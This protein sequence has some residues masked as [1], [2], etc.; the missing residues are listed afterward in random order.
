M[1]RVILR[2]TTLIAILLAPVGPTY[3]A[4]IEPFPT[5]EVAP[6]LFV[7]AA[8]IA[9]A[10][11][12]NLGAIANLGFVIGREA[13]A[14]IDTGGSLA[15]GQRLA[16]SIRARTDLPVRW[17][18]NT[19]VH[20]DHMLGN[21]AFVRPGVTFVGH[22]NLPQALAARADGYLAANRALVGEA[23]A[24][25]TIVPPTRLVDGALDLDLGGRVLHLE[26]WPTAHTNTDL[27]V[28]D[29]ATQT[30]FLGDLLFTGHVPALDGRLKGWI[31]ILRSL[32]ERSA[33]RVVPGHGPA[34]VSWPAAAAPI[35]RY[36][37][38][39]EGDV[40]R[41]IRAGDTMRETAARAGTSESA[42]WS[43]FDA[44]NPRNAT[45]AY[46]ELEWE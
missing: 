14:V 8:P 35:E 28:L 25:T 41:A 19:H 32:R 20:P 23:F 36:L 17:V 10:A 27:T 22:H 37:S 43:L 7:Y 45:S 11:P 24:G 21:A 3:A 38:V 15:A 1:I 30:W 4:E 6:G 13:V 29:V 39:L 31:A 33:E 18:I 44:F 46:Q 5:E 26:S 9:V 40:R 16:A 12:D 34:S 42:A 2:A